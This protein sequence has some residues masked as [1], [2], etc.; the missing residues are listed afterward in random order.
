MTTVGERETM[1]PTEMAVEDLSAAARELDRAVHREVF[2]GDVRH[3]P[4]DA[5]SGGEPTLPPPTYTVETGESLPRYAE[6]LSDAWQ[7]VEHLRA[8]SPRLPAGVHARFVEIIGEHRTALFEKPQRV[9]AEMICRTA[10][11]ATRQE[12]LTVRGRC[13]QC[14]EQMEQVGYRERP[15]DGRAEEVYLCESCGSDPTIFAPLPGP[16]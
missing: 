13:P 15:G 2:G 16:A 6:S 11:R 3:H 12:S 10:L 14:G 4:P 7:V 5:A 1:D 8:G 9:A